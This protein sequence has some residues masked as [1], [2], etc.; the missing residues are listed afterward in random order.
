[1]EKTGKTV[2]IDLGITNFIKM[3]DGTEVHHPRAY[4]KESKRLAALQ[5][6]SDRKKRGSNRRRKA[7][8]SLAKLHNRVHNIRIDFQH[9]AV[10]KLVREYD[11]IVIEKLNI[12]SML[13]A[14]GFEVNKEN[15]SDASWGSFVAIL[16][17]KAERA[18]KTVIEVNPAN[19]SRTCSHCGNIDKDMTLSDRIYH[20]HS[21]GMAMDRDQN[22]AINIKRLGMN[23]AE[24]NY[25]AEASAFGPR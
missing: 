17:Y 25:S 6:S 4:K 8:R 15:I 23:R 12:K 2:G 19:T 18:G 10:L 11:I 3:D 5:R 13:E 24:L 21:C 9:K 1:L 7:K 20:C 22:A 16:K 14:K